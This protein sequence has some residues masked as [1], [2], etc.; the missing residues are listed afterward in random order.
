MSIFTMQIQEVNSAKTSLLEIPEGTVNGEVCLFDEEG[1][2]QMRVGQGC[3]GFTHSSKGLNRRLTSWKGR[4]TACSEAS[5]C[6]L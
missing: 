4:S 2:T 1:G 5:C 3:G 6:T